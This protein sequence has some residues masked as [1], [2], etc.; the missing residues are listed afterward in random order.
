MYSISKWNKLMKNM[1]SDK[2]LWEKKK[3]P[4]TVSHC[5][6]LMPWAG[7]NK[8]LH[9]RET[10]GTSEI[11]QSQSRF[12]QPTKVSQNPHL[13]FQETLLCTYRV[14]T[15]HPKECSGIRWLTHTHIDR[16]R[17]RTVDHSFAHPRFLSD[18]QGK[19]QLNAFSLKNN[20]HGSWFW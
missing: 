2:N 19:L 3:Q 15:S 13:V 5:L 9:E 8:C 4:W 7:G 10:T 16:H 17:G 11:P 6:H 1:Y 20:Q 14:V 18:L 12:F